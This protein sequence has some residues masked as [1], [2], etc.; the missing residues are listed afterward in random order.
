MILTVC[1]LDFDTILCSLSWK[2]DNLTRNILHF[3]IFLD[4]IHCNINFSLSEIFLK[5]LLP[6]ILIEDVT[7]VCLIKMIDV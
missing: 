4:I 5:C 3:V 1:P 7:D 6:L 2:T